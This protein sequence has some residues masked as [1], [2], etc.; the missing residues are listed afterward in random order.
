[1]GKERSSPNAWSNLSW[2]T[3]VFG[4]ADLKEIES[5]PVSKSEQQA[6]LT[7]LIAHEYAHF[8][9]ETDINDSS[10][11]KSRHGFK[12]YVYYILNPP[13]K[14]EEYQQY[15]DLMEGHHREV[16][17]VAMTLMKQCKMAS[18]DLDS[19][20]LTFDGFHTKS[21]LTNSI[22]SCTN[23]R[24]RSLSILRVSQQK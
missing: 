24:I 18:P 4:E 16:D 20:L 9:V 3:I 6:V 5:L 8:I 10:D 19:L 22:K 11:K 15:D 17:A 13:R 21:N 12:S 2:N 23:D 7:F 14:I 1:M